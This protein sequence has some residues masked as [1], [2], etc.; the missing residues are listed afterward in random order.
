MWLTIDL[1]LRIGLS[2]S[3][4]AIW[5]YAVTAQ[6][7][8]PNQPLFIFLWLL[9]GALVLNMPFSF[10]KI[11]NACGILECVMM[12]N[13]LI[14][15]RICGGILEFV[16]LVRTLISWF[17]STLKSSSY[18]GFE[19][20]KYHLT[21]SR[22]M[23]E[24]FEQFSSLWVFV[25]CWKLSFAFFNFRWSTK[26]RES[27]YMPGF[28]S[29]SLLTRDERSRLI[30]YIFYNDRILRD[31]PTLGSS[32]S[33]MHCWCWLRRVLCFSDTCLRKQL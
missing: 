11:V 29:F 23:A 16:L 21:A 28:S 20:N 15:G 19:Q 18:I 25:S 26:V 7:A 8:G 12:V 24:L 33:S 17:F 6:N 13:M 1:W 31:F 2:L 9:I 32:S 4:F 14:G 22:I 5:L 10:Y 3:I 30:L 27:Y